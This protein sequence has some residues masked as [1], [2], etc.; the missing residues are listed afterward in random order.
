MPVT[1]TRKRYRKGP[2]AFVCIACDKL[3]ESHRG[4]AVTCS[5]AC[6]VWIH[7][8]PERLASLRA[9]CEALKVE[10]GMVQECAAAGRLRPD[11]S[12][13]IGAGELSVH[14]VRADVHREFLRLVFATV[15][16]RH[17]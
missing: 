10:P 1:D 2:R 9:T 12:A 3:A 16:N 15:R 5:P 17:D 4:H 13:L 11:L 7:R 8:H 14:D 6:R